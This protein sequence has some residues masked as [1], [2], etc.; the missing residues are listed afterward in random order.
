MAVKKLGKVF[1]L[2]LLIYLLY[3]C[4]TAV[5]IFYIPIEKDAQLKNVPSFLG[6]DSTDRV[7]L[8]ENG[9]DSGVARIQMI[10]EAEQSID[11]AYFSFGKGKTAELF[12]GTLLDAADRGVKIRILLD[13]ICHGLRGKMSD[14]RFA[15]ASHK[16]IELR[17]Y[18]SVDLLKPWTWH[19][20]LHDKIMTV[21]RKL[22]IIGG[23]N[24]GD[25]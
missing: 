25:K 3:V 24:I 18:E 21:D 17:Y 16:N 22:S 11:I 13:G 10:Q 2:V 20:R 23:R 6:K 4:V 19:N 5:G 7:L 8:L 1:L 12:L 9:Y 14:A 15:L